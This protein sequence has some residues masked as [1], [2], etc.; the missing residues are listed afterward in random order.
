MDAYEILTQATGFDWDGGNL[1]KNWITHRVAASEYEQVFFNQPL[2]VAPDAAHSREEPRLLLLGQTDAGR[3]LFVAFTLRQD[4]IRIISARP[5]S[6]KERKV[7]GQ[8]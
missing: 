5:M 4:L 2:V 7:Y 8:S 6:R 3:L 1:E